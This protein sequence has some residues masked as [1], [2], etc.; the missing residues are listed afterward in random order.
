[1]YTVEDISFNKDTH[2]E[3]YS[4]PL[5]SFVIS[6]ANESLLVQYYVPI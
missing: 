4:N 3:S 2:I 1:M 5:F 6:S